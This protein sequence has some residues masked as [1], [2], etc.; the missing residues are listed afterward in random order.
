MG[1]YLCSWLDFKTV[2][3]NRACCTPHNATQSS[4][5]FRT[6]L[7]SHWKFVGAAY[8]FLAHPPHSGLDHRRKSAHFLFVG[9]DKYFT[10]IVSCL[11]KLCAWSLVEV[12]C[13]SFSSSLPMLSSPKP[14]LSIWTTLPFLFVVAT[15]QLCQGLSFL[16]SVTMVMNHHSLCMNV[17]IDGALGVHLV[18]SQLTLMFLRTTCVCVCC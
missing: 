5:C 12:L 8:L 17:C 13:P 6:P 3:R 1:S 14:L 18:W 9:A 2:R 4:C 11:H 15:D 16:Y 10:A 7:Y